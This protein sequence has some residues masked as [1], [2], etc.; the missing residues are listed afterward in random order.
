[1]SSSTAIT[2]GP[3]HDDAWRPALQMLKVAG[4]PLR[5]GVVGQ[6]P[7]LLLVNGIGANIEMW[8]ALARRLPDR[9]LVMFDFPGTGASPTMRR[10][11][12]MPALARLV[13]R[14][15]DEL[16]IERTDVL[17]YS[18]GGALA[19]ELAHQAPDRIGSLV[20]AATTPG[21]GGQAPAPWVIAA[22]ATP[23]RYYSPTFLR[24]VAPLI[25]GAP[26]QDQTHV[27]ARRQRPPAIRGYLHQLY[28]ISGWSSRPWLRRLRLPVLVLAGDGDR[29]APMGNARIMARAIPGARLEVIP[30]GHLFLLE[31]PDRAAGVIT[32]F[33]DERR[34]R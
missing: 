8:E 24:L 18:W 6:G 23:L 16:S 12:R 7:T 14:L 28:A 30:G 32:A 2:G 31:Q 25:Y 29:L 34:P 19:Q 1:M 20:L 33:L 13:V 9:R 21:L 10:Q 15:L 11:R 4:V 17:G 27:G 3:P 22:M 5:V 26:V